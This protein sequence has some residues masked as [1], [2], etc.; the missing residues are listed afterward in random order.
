MVHDDTDTLFR[1]LGIA[2]KY[3]GQGGQKRIQYTLP[4]LVFAAL[5]LSTVVR[6]VRRIGRRRRRRKRG[7]WREAEDWGCCYAC[8]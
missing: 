1:F 3:L 4:P 5:R 7:G 8:Y 2:R 6:K